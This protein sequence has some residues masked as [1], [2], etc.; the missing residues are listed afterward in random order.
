MTEGD[1]PG[2]ER[3]R[4]GMPVDVRNVSLTVLAILGIIFALHALREAF[5]PIVLAILISYALGP[6]VTGLRR[7]YVPRIIGAALVLGALVAGVGTAAYALQYEAVQIVNELPRAARRLR[8]T[9]QYSRRQ[10]AFE[11]VQRAATEIDKTAAEATPPPPPPKGVM[12]VQIEQPAF[13]ASDYL[14]WGSRGA[15][16][17]SAQIV[18]IL[19]LAYFLLVSGD[20]FK[21]KLVRIAGPS[22]EAR[23]ITVEILDDVNAQI[24][25]F[26]LVQIFAAVVVWLTTWIALWWLGLAQA[27][28]WGILAGIFNTIPY[29]GPVVVSAGLAI[30]AY[31][32]FGTIGMALTVTAIAMII[33]SLEGWLLTPALVGRAARMNQAAVLVGLIFGG[34]L[35]GVWGVLLAAPMMM[36]VKAVCDRVE[37][38]QPIAEL[39]GE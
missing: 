6:V 4:I 22:Q 12:R 9:L 1:N 7:L 19:F 14:W 37:N 38:L 3:L 13:R 25:R 20:L 33:T 5:I 27:A 29:F 36:V 17:A 26:L 30:V 16:A 28:V 23:R 2:R 35:W 24:E 10:G 15:A 11:T 8:E 32:Q 34:V 18:L 21:R 39:L 31:M